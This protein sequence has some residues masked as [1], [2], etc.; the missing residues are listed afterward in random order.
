MYMLCI[1]FYMNSTRTL[2]WAH[3]THSNTFF[4]YNMYLYKYKYF[5][6]YRM[7]IISR[8]LSCFYCVS[9]EKRKVI[10][11]VETY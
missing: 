1:H 5:I 10:V 11:V 6:L 7:C 2:T 3:T 8:L 4:V 9:N